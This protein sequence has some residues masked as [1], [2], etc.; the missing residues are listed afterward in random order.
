MSAE[1]NDKSL[2]VAMVIDTYDD[3]RNGAVISTQRF[4]NL[5]RKHGHGVTVITTGQ[6][7]PG[8]LV[9]KEFYPPVPLI[10]SVM[11]RMKFIFAW[12][13]SKKIIP[14]LKDI[15]VLHNHM[16]FYLSFKSIKLATQ[17]GVPVVSTFHVQAEQIVNNIGL[18]SRF[19]V[20]LVYKFFIWLIYNRSNL[21]ICPSQFA[22]DEIKRY[23]CKTPTAVISNGVTEDYRVLNLPKTHPDKFVILT[24]GRNAAEKRQ[25]MIIKAISAS[26]YKDQIL[27]QIVGDGP[28]RPYLVQK[29][30]E[31]LDGQVEFQYLPP[32]EVIN[33]YN[34]ADLYVHAAA[35]EVEC[36]TALEAMACGLPLLIADT[37]LSATKQF[38]IHENNLFTSV[39]ELTRKIEYWIEHRDELARSRTDYLEFVRK[40]R[41]EESYKNLEAAYRNAI[42]LKKK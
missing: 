35:V 26:K 11:Q 30:R 18:K 13:N 28:L 2:K 20:W 1:T 15:D 17:A 8:K 39:D 41:I 7:E 36:M 9:M 32:N 22:S 34:T 37:E 4:T 40:Y 33:Y 25:E 12:P 6:P 31:L 24:V 19:L 16:P 42:G 5:L 38:A 10:K 29:S 14:L 23:G 27:L 21:V 3:A